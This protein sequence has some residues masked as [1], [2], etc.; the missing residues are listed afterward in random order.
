M[1]APVWDM[2]AFAPSGLLPDFRTSTGFFSW[3]RRVICLHIFRNSLPFVISS[4]YITMTLVCSCSASILRIST[5]LRSTL[6][7]ILITDENPI[8]C[9][10]ASSTSAAQI[11]PLWDT[12]AI[13]PDFGVT[14]R[15]VEF[16][17]VCGAR[18][19][20]PRQFGP[21]I[22]ILYCFAI[23]A[24][25]RSSFAPSSLTSLNPAVMTIAPLIFFLPH[26]SSTAGTTSFFVT[27]TARSI[28][29][30]TSR[31]LLYAFL[32]NIVSR[33]GLI[34]RIFPVY[35]FSM[36]DVMARP[37][38]PSLSEAPIMA[39]DFGD[40]KID[41]LI[42]TRWTQMYLYNKF[43]QEKHLIPNI[44]LTA[45]HLSSYILVSWDPV[46][47]QVWKLGCQFPCFS[48]KAPQ[49]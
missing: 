14:F 10:L 23:S 44:R 45:K 26:S 42:L 8:P 30:G 46:Y 48:C 11:A 1:R 7:P 33:V 49:L 16:I 13:P 9:A 37:T 15:K 17:I 28:S 34:G 39:I 6:L 41:S 36:F 47:L 22:L 20:T 38:L 24:S 29:S 25:F 32:S 3:F 2:A 21:M 5:S 40:R 35:P 31:T 18:F 19:I 12:S 43:I 4:R 27:I